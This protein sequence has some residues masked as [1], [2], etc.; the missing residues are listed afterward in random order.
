MSEGSDTFAEPGSQW[1]KPPL[2]APAE[3]VASRLRRLSRWQWGLVLVVVVYTS[4]FTWLSMRLH[5]GL[6]TSTYDYALYDQGVWLM[7]RFKAPFVTLMGRNLLGDHTS[8]ILVLLVPL[9]WIVP[10]AG[11]LLFSQSFAAAISCVPV[12]L[13][14]RRRLG[15]E[16]VALLLAAAYLIHPA[17][18][19]GN[20]E[21][22]H[23]DVFLAPLVMFAI[24]FALIERWRWYV[25]FVALALLVR[26]DVSL[27]I[28][29]LGVW[30]AL[31]R[32]RI[33]GLVTVAASAVYAL[34]ALALMKLLIGNPFPN[35][36]RIPFGG[37]GG[38]LRETGARPGNVVDY[39]RSDG[40]L[41]Y[42]WQMVTP[43]A[44]VALRLPDVALIS[45]LVLT[46]NVVSTFGYQH[47]I[48]YHY[49][50]VALPA[51]ALGTAYA[52]AVLSG[53]WRRL[54]ITGV[55]A[56]S[57]WT[58]FLWGPLPI[59]REPIAYWEPDFFVAEQA[60]DIIRG[61]PD[62]AVVSAHFL[63]TP[64]LARREQ[65]YMFP[66]PF[67]RVLYGTDVSL[68]GTPLP[69]AADVEFVVLRSIRDT[70][71]DA[72]WAVVDDFFEL[73]RVNESWELYRRREPG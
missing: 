56:M 23:P 3:W 41:F 61:I 19:W 9:Y 44:W 64:H 32:D 30:V 66:N 4:Y 6:G 13:Y 42:V 65:I 50:V 49:S 72:H 22:F 15:N 43:F 5:Y 24:Y 53:R 33:I 34:L 54:A 45:I 10:G 55:A 52:I 39:L 18:Q 8:L 67:S 71:D 2:V 1:R 37:F 63:L 28:V 51:L 68:E 73:V 12:F 57:L 47:Q 27:V 21:D 58:A 7:S 36:W 62:D 35:A 69:A 25:V 17:L 26:E 40:R 38:F 14:A 46:S 11:T 20:L 48:I 60:R 31:R 59:A 29:P 70:A 16:G